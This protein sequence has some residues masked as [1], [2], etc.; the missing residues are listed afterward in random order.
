MLARSALVVHLFAP[1][2]GDRHDEALAHL[3]RVWE[4]CG[5][6]LGMTEAVPG[7]GVGADFPADGPALGLLAARTGSGPGLSQVALRRERDAVCLSALMQPE[8][9]DW[10]RLDARWSEVLGHDD[11]GLL[12][13]AR[14]FLALGEA[15]AESIRMAPADP[16]APAGWWRGGITVPPGLSVWEMSAADDARAERRLVVVAGHDQD[17][18]LTAWVWTTRERGLPPLARYLLHAAK[19]RYQ[20]RVWSASEPIGSLRSRTDTAIGTLLERITVAERGAGPLSELIAAGHVVLDLQARERGLTD[21]STRNR[22][23]ARTVRIAAVNLT[24]LG[25]PALGGPFTDDQALAEWLEQRLDDETTYLDAASHR[26]ERTGALADQFVERALQRRQQVINLGLTGVIGAILMSLAAVQ[27]L[28]YQVPL[29]GPVKPAVVAALGALALLAAFVVLRAVA[30]DRRWSSLLLRGAAAGIGA[31]LAWL[32]VAV[33]TGAGL[34]A[35]V[36]WACATAGAALAVT[37]QR[38]WSP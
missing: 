4:D 28:E 15:T 18:A 9:S 29:P 14:L 38:R 21:R 7:T 33:C 30:P 23:M 13:A 34:P 27:S 35:A 22:E 8:A 25:D 31:T 37:I 19:L 20:L 6:D 17:P 3:A 11:H 26:A 36:T 16:E 5:N 32:A 2:G 1:S 24:Q 10:R 12:G